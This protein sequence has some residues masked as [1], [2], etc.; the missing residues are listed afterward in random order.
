[1]VP[2]P[3]SCR[4]QM[5][6]LEAVVKC[7]AD[8]L[9]TRFEKF[10]LEHAAAFEGAGTGAEEQKHEHFQVF[11]TFCATFEKM[12]TDFVEEQGGNVADFQDECE[13]A[14]AAGGQHGWF[15]DV[16]LSNLE[17]KRFYGLM[18]NEVARLKMTGQLG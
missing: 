15:L 12:I 14:K 3:S 9:D 17:Y 16:M 5:P 4:H 11:E 7:L 10:A 2:P 6:L 13:A 1:M 8:D 18:K